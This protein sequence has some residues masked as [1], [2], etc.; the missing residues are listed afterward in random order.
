[1]GGVTGTWDVSRDCL[2]VE[3]INAVGRHQGHPAPF[4]H[5]AVVPRAAAVTADV[6]V[7]ESP[8][9]PHLNQSPGGRRNNS[10]RSITKQIK[11][12]A[13]LDDL[14]QMYEEHQGQLNPYQLTAMMSR[15]ALLTSSAA[16]GHHHALVDLLTK[17]LLEVLD[18]L[19]PSLLSVCIWSFGMAKY[20]PDQQQVLPAFMEALLQEASDQG[21][22]LPD[23]VLDGVGAEK[24]LAGLIRLRAFKKDWFVRLEQLGRECVMVEVAQGRLDSLVSATIK[25]LS[26]MG[27]LVQL[28]E[29]YEGQT[30]AI[31][32]SAFFCRM[33][34]LLEGKRVEDSEYRD[35][36]DLVG[37]RL[38][39]VVEDA[40]F[41]I[42]TSCLGAWGK[43]QYCPD[44]EQTLPV[45][46][47]ALLRS[48]ADD[49]VK[50]SRDSYVY[51]LTY[52]VEALVRLGA[53][54]EG[55]YQKMDELAVG[56]SK[57]DIATVRLRRVLTREVKDTATI[58]Q[59]K[60]L[61]LSHCEVLNSIHL[62][63]F[64]SRAAV[65][66]EGQSVE[67]SDWQPF[68]DALTERLR[69]GVSD[70]G[71]WGLCN[72]ISALGQMQ[73]C[74]DCERTVTVFMEALLKSQEG[75]LGLLW[76]SQ[77]IEGLDRLGCLKEEWVTRLKALTGPATLSAGELA[78][79]SRV[80]TARIRETSSMDRLI[81]LYR[82]YE[83]DLN[84]MQLCAVCSRCHRL[85]I[86]EADSV[87]KYKS[88]LDEVT[89][90]LIAV[91]D[92]LNCRGLANCLGSWGGMG[93]CMDKHN[94]VTLFMGAL[95]RNLDDG[96]MLDSLSGQQAL[97]CMVRLAVYQEQ[98]ERTLIRRAPP[99]LNVEVML[100]N[101]LGSVLNKAASVEVLRELLKAFKG[102][103]TNLH[104][105]VICHRLGDLMARQ[106]STDESPYI[107]FVTELTDQMLGS[108]D[109]LGLKDLSNLVSLWG[110][111]K[112]CPQQDSTLPRVMEAILKD[113]ESSKEVAWMS[114]V[115]TLVGL[116]A[117]NA[118]R[119]DWVDRLC[120]GLKAS[121]P[122]LGTQTVPGL[123][124]ALAEA[125]YD[126]EEVF[127]ILYTMFSENVS[128]YKAQ[129]LAKCTKAL[130]C[131]GRVQQGLMDQVFD[132]MLEQGRKVQT[133]SLSYL[134]LH[135]AQLSYADRTRLDALLL[136]I[137]KRIP[138]MLSRDVLNILTALRLFQE[139]DKSLVSETLLEKLSRRLLYLSRQTLMKSSGM[140]AALSEYEALGYQPLNHLQLCHF[141][142]LTS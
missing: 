126:D 31:H 51:S 101:I 25:E 4:L 57:G 102:R 19:T 137:T 39:E 142:E 65:L 48:A 110:K 69:A 9:P 2:H 97:E 66:L 113:K 138:A 73:Y 7:A 140:K 106:R 68:V 10:M 62:S 67:G 53:Y 54:N 108:L 96:Q 20:C 21:R 128:S 74:P 107:D 119:K 36:V 120:V 34:I 15:V 32:I 139:L 111:L 45:I 85:V 44:Q 100:N 84:K 72:S 63:T 43:M 90:R 135:A 76:A 117:L 87:A 24:V 70:M 33:A 95:L 125:G 38:L 98:W 89:L 131:Q 130:V 80:M 116:V 40:S 134:L 35:F 123:L 94:T 59:L 93:Y 118:C 1:M 77:V 122:S 3:R 129:D 11:M 29:C 22:Y 41:G 88:F 71:S 47:Q 42:L 115:Y 17:D 99:D 132:A 60:K 49:E 26:T 81:A 56:F 86:A 64:L 27:E 78:R 58:E 12:T 92:E 75:S 124:W 141:T 83:A 104:Y 50:N 82:Q 6:E 14:V 127:D 61:Y 16:E 114:L 5:R 79:M 105:S 136:R 55:W 23:E 121:L 46:M 112:Y 109:R 28:Y 133:I 91:K 52:I 18:V 30:N 37:R 103:F 8:S 13:T